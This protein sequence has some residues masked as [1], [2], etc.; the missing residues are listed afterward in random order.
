MALGIVYSIDPTD[1]TKGEVKENETEQI[2]P[3]V[4]TNFP[5]SGLGLNSNCTYDI[6]YTARTPTATNLAAYVPSEII[7][8]TPTAGPLTVNPG[9]TMRVKTGGVV[10]GNVNI[11]NGNLFV[12][13]TGEVNGDVTVDQQG[14]FIA[15]KGGKVN[16][17]VNIM[18]GSAMKVVNKGRI[19]GN[20]VI[21]QANRFIMGNAQDGGTI[22]GSVTVDKIRKV[23]IT[24]TSKINP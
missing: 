5:T 9:E 10:T 17:N 6:D 16:G 7:I 2:Y 1:N 3:F 18:N 23:T 22:V 11:N 13:E 24:P 4:D 15:R 14:S 19:T 20:V 21:K 8:D 12:E